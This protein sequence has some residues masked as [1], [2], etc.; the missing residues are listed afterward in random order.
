MSRVAY[1][2]LTAATLAVYFV[3]VLWTLPTI[4]AAAGG[5]LPFDLRPWGYSPEEA[6]AFLSVL[7][8]PGRSLYSDVQLRLDTVYP[9]LLAIWICASAAR[10]FPRGVVWAI[11]LVAVGGMAADLAENAAVAQLLDGFDA[12]TARR[13]ARW[14]M[15][16]SAATTLALTA[17]LAGFVA[18]L[19]G[20]WRAR[21]AG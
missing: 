20:V 21:G 5:A 1:L 3:M 6:A 4:A 11:G 15:V 2:I 13:A 16:K 19:W 8:D 12:D 7:S 18:W 9:P 10:L 14:T 17:L